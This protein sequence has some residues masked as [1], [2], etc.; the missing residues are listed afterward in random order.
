MATHPLAMEKDKFH[1]RCFQ[2]D[3]RYGADQ[4]HYLCPCCASG[5]RP[6]QPPMGV[7]Q[8]EYDYTRL[9]EQ[10]DVFRQ[11]AAS[12]FIGLLPIASA[13]SLPPLRVGQTPLYSMKKFRG[14]ALPRALHIKDDGQNPTFSY[15]DRASAL[16]SAYARERGFNTIVVASTGNAGS[17]MAGICASQRQRAIVMVP[18]AAPR[19]KLV[20]ILMYGARIVPVD[21]SYDDAFDLS[22]AATAEHGWYNRNTG[23]NPLTVEGK[24]TAAFEIFQQ[25]K[26]RL[27]GRIFVPV[28]DGVILSGLYKGFEELMWLGLTD[29]VPELVAVQAAGSPNLAGNLDNP[30]FKT[31]A[32]RTLADS[33][34]VDVPRNFFMARHYIHRY[35]GRAMT[36]SDQEILDASALLAR[37]TGLFTEPASAAAFAGWLAAGRETGPDGLAD[38]DLVL[39]TGSGLKDLQAVADMIA[40][41]DPV[42]PDLDSLNQYLH[43]NGK[44]LL[45]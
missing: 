41:P 3:T 5:N 36:V 7:L 39:L 33:I 23:H 2:C 4:V 32:G 1:Y 30:E 21:G 11:L 43:T 16:V 13:D 22:L 35:E 45:T 9:R 24:K 31:I 18:A 40:L 6:G 15:K 14:K 20:Q 44:N 38:D 37:E 17:S 10:K 29:R 8:V 28:G 34:S 42:N 12:G 27:P 26:G 19:A 25:T